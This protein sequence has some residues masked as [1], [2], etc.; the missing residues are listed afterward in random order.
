MSGATADGWE[1]EPIREDLEVLADSD[2]PLAPVAQQLLER[3]PKNRKEVRT[4]A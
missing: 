3:A 4:T 2:G 1:F